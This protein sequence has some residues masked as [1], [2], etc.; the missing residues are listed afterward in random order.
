MGRT[1][2]IQL[3]SKE[4]ANLQCKPKTE[5]L[6]HCTLATVHMVLCLVSLASIFLL[7]FLLQGSCGGTSLSTSCFCQ[8]SGPQ[9][10]QGAPAPHGHTGAT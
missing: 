8:A 5:P 3:V 7:V 9:V 6:S 1:K 10:P 2:V 4:L